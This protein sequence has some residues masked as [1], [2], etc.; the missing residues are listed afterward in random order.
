MYDILTARNAFAEYL[1]NSA[2][3]KSVNKMGVSI[4]MYDALK[5][6]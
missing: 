5:K 2:V 6:K 4:Y 3:L 1:I